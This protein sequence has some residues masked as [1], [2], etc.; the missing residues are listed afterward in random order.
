M[1]GVQYNNGT[2]CDLRVLEHLNIRVFGKHRNTINLTVIT[3]HVLNIYF[4]E[5]IISDCLVFIQNIK[6]MSCGFSQIC[7]CK[8]AQKEKSELLT[9]TGTISNAYQSS[10]SYENQC[11]IQTLGHILKK[12]AHI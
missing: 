6:Y 7:W 3:V 4:N 2:K 5:H 11:Q 9:N 8:T 12:S 1:E 10:T